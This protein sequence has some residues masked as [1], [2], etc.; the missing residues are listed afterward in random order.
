MATVVTRK[1]SDEKITTT[2]ITVTETDRIVQFDDILESVT[3]EFDEWFSEAPWEWSDGWEH[4]YE[5]VGYNHHDGVE[6]SR[7]CG[8]SDANRERFLITVSDEQIKEWGN[9]DYYHNSGCSKQVA[10]ELV[11]QV[12]RDALDQLV[13]WYSN[14]WEW[15]L[16][17]GEYK[18]YTAGVGGIDCPDHAEEMRYEIA[19]EIATN[20][21]ADG[22][23]VE[24]QHNPHEY[25]KLD[26]T[27]DRFKRNLQ[28]DVVKGQ[29]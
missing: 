7:G 8:Y 5:S 23:I 2:S 16:T 1:V 20:M 19:G 28:L 14:G 24:G 12:K 22:Y 6:E 11:A 26:A 25:D 17:G 9:Y 21:E 15:Y 13:K 4:D 18:G 3:V 29:G 10:A 27:K